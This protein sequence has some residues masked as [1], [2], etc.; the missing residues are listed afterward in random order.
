[1]DCV[2]I[3]LRGRLAGDWNT[4]LDHSG[5]SQ[6]PQSVLPPVTRWDRLSPFFTGTKPELV[7]SLN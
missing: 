1:M 6:G 7:R 4:S 3:R 2:E 5:E